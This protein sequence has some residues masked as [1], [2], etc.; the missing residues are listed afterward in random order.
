MQVLKKIAL[1][2]I[3]IM[4]VQVFAATIP[5]NIGDFT[6]GMNKHAGFYSFYYDD[7]AGKVYVELNRFEQP[8]IFQSSLP[9]GLGS[10]DIGL[11]RGQLGDTRLVQFERFGEKVLLKQL[12]TY[13]NANSDN[14][15]ERES[16]KEAFSSSVIAGFKVVASE[17]KRVLID[18]SEFLMSDIHGVA[19]RLTATK[20]GSYKVDSNRT[21]IYPKR[22]RAFPKNTELEAMITFGGSKPGKF[23]KQIA[24]DPYSLT[25]RMH[26]SFV[27]LP[28]EHYQTR[29]FS[30]FAGF[31][32]MEFK[33]YSTPIDQ[34]MEQRVI[35]RHRLK[36][37]ACQATLCEP[38]DP[39]VYYLDPGVPEPVKGALI[40]G[41]SWWN[42]AFEAIGYKDAFVVKVL[43]ADADP[44]DIRFNVI[45]W[46]HRATRG[47]SYGSSVIDP[48]TGEIIKGHVTL[49]SLRVRQDLLIARGLTAS[50]DDTPQQRETAKAMALD[51][52]RQLSA[53]EVGHTLGIAHN[54]AAS[55]KDRASV[56]DYPQ[57]LVT[58]NSSG[59]VVLT[60]AYA[61]GI[62]PW[63]K[64]VIAYGYS[65]LTGDEASELK[66]L[67]Q[68]AKAQGLRFI[69]DPD[70]RSVANAH[71]DSHLWDNGNEPIAELKKMIKIREKA[72]NGFGLANLDEGEPL[73][74]LEEKLVPIYLYHRYQTQAVAKLVGGLDYDYEVK[75]DQP[76][77]GGTIVSSKQQQAALAVLLDTIE[78]DFLALQPQTLQLLIPKAYGYSRNRESFKNRTG[79]TFDPLAISEV[80]ARHTISALLNS[81]RL[82]RMQEQASRVKK[83]LS[84][85]QMV[86]QLFERTIKAKPQTGLAS[87]IQQRVSFVAIELVMQQIQSDNIGPQ[88]RAALYN[89]V[90]A[91]QTW[92]GNAAKKSKNPHHAMYRLLKQ[93]LTWFE[94]SG[95]WQSHFKLLDLPPGSPI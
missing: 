78:A 4:P 37:K 74:S 27:Q 39:I 33:D 28:D 5:T 86:E 19:R 48:R 24:P 88:V 32:S 60:D 22:S 77:K 26:H 13:F 6:K 42:Q 65:E 43:P 53:H 21:V 58:L 18:Y 41:A 73:S 69:S 54:F 20:Q 50:L 8:F 70:S 61:K 82:H 76:A 23:V 46:V 92:L 34:L 56:M 72:L 64:Y 84:V 17:Q 63:D 80:A 35:P 89:E 90:M 66:A 45:Q 29:R 2:L 47:W 71:P 51:R 11:D 9:A 94:Q 16:I 52:I 79:V 81:Q 57:P 30:A 49:G 12:N 75:S 95:Q 31:L 93:Q 14:Q 59:D 7:K 62:A 85:E 68:Q 38:V 15:A 25:V 67:E 87:Q 44:M 1:L 10:N 40:D 91:L 3:L 36:K 55:G 83:G